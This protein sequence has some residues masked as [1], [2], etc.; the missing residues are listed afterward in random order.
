M[1]IILCVEGD[2]KEIESYLEAIEIDRDLIKSVS[3]EDDKNV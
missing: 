2:L 1:K 3:F